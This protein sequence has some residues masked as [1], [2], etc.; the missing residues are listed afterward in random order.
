MVHD[1]L[2]NLSGA[3]SFDGFTAR[4]TERIAPTLRMAASHVRPGGKVFL[5]KGSGWREELAAAGGWEDSWVHE[6][7]FKLSAGPIVVVVFSK[8]A[9]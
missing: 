6:T 2:E 8:K 4:A 7:S 9:M 1:R 5:W 3:G